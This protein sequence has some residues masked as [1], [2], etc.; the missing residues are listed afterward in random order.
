MGGNHKGANIQTFNI[1]IDVHPYRRVTVKVLGSLLLRFRSSGRTLEARRLQ[2]LAHSSKVDELKCSFRFPT[3]CN[4]ADFDF[5][6]SV[7]GILIE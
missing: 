7:Q 3:L 1:I 6:R 2:A 4:F 5:R